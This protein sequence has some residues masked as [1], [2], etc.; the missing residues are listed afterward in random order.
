MVI[1]TEYD[2]VHK[3]LRLERG[4]ADKYECA[5][6]GCYASA[7]VWAW[8]RRG[9]FR[10][11]VGRHGRPLT[12]GIA[13][14]DYAPMCRSHAGMLDR[15]GTIDNCPRGHDRSA[16]KDSHGFCLACKAEDGR[17]EKRLARLRA[18]YAEKKGR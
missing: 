4:R 3:R 6:G 5:A 14:L 13:T 17:S 11:G 10:I 9:P 16:G 7:A 8:L 12:W 1:S 18:R 2:A 15:G